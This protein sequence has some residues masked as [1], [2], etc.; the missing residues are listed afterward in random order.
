MIADYKYKDMIIPK[1]A[2]V[3]ISTY[4]MAIDPELWDEP[5]VFNPEPAA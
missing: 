3:I 1:G 5:L 2:I 4:P